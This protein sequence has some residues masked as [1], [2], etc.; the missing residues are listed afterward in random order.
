MVLLAVDPRNVANTPF[1]S[2]VRNCYTL[3]AMLYKYVAK[4]Y[5]YTYVAKFE[6]RTLSFTYLASYLHNHMLCF[7]Q[8]YHQLS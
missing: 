5:V 3:I 7:S 6:L 4:F 8:K 2:V 1:I